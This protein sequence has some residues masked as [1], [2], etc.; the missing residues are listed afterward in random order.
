M[1]TYI[2]KFELEKNVVIETVYNSSNIN[3][4]RKYRID[5]ST[6]YSDHSALFVEHI[7]SNRENSISEFNMWREYNSISKQGLK[8]IN[9]LQNK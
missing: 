6:R 1:E 4:I 3:Y 8:A 5:V 9:I 7:F 2:G